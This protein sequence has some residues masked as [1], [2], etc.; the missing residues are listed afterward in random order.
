MK[1]EL[2][3]L[4]EYVDYLEAESRMVRKYLDGYDVFNTGSISDDVE[5]FVES[6][7]DNG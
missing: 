7:I 4:Q 1:T 6:V 2:Q 5:I 3:E